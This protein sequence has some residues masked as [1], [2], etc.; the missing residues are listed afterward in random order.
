MSDEK[1]RDE[2]LNGLLQRWKTPAP[3]AS[4]DGRV[5]ASFRRQARRSASWRWLFWLPVAAAFLV[6]AIWIPR[7]QHPSR[8]LE[9]HSVWDAAGASYV[10]QVDA[11]GFQPAP[12]GA[13]AIT[14][15]K[16]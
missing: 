6:A 4:L 16:P 8:N 2:S 9:L 11:S 7:L 1:G 12:E 3:P 13:I 5:L 14:G 15:P 10:T